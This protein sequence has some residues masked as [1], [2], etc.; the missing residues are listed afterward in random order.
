VLHKL[1]SLVERQPCLACNIAAKLMLLMHTLYLDVVQFGIQLEQSP[2]RYENLRLMAGY[3][4][5]H[6]VAMTSLIDM[7]EERQL[8]M[9]EQTL[10]REM[11]R[12]L[13]TLI[14]GTMLSTGEDVGSDLSPR[15]QDHHEDWAASGKKIEDL[16]DPASIQVAIA[17]I[18]YEIQ[19]DMGG[20]SRRTINK[21]L[22]KPVRQKG[23]KDMASHLLIRL[24]TWCSEDL[25]YRIL[26]QFS[27][28]EVFHFQTVRTC[29]L[30]EL[31]F[32]TNLGKYLIDI[33]PK[34]LHLAG[35]QLAFY[36][37]VY[38]LNA[39]T[40][41]VSVMLLCGTASKL[42]LLLPP[43][44]G[45]PLGKDHNEKH[46]HRC[47][48][49]LET[50]PNQIRSIYRG[51]GKQLLGFQ[52]CNGSST[53]LA[54]LRRNARDSIAHFLHRASGDQPELRANMFTDP[55]TQA[56]V[57]EVVTGTVLAAS[58]TTNPVASLIEGRTVETVFGLEGIPRLCVLTSTE[59]YEFS[60][61]FVAWTAADTAAPYFD[62]SE[63]ARRSVQGGQ[64]GDGSPSKQSATSLSKADA[65]DKPKSG[66]RPRFACTLPGFYSGKNASAQ[67]GTEAPLTLLKSCPLPPQKVEF[68][69]GLHPD[70][71]IQ[72]SQSIEIRFCTDGAREEWR[73]VLADICSGW[74]RN[75]ED[76]K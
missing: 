30:M 24:L 61:D 44:T 60:L 74:Q 58:V 73:R 75:G 12:C 46:F 22:A 62:E 64:L 59:V 63:G 54:F 47:S 8:A 38:C 2:P 45:G 11:C 14:L 18:L 33:G 4:S 57:E 66:S 29:Y 15:G 17:F 27:Q 49:E 52:W 25:R 68:D 1:I 36:E 26:E 28:A 5:Q 51:Y 43:S 72:G 31:L 67:E 39:A 6:A 76:A 70:L 42:W 34:T 20:G 10:G 3:I 13:S 55:S 41:T 7:T 48:I 32:N 23:L 37:P 69:V 35:S 71:S 53:L 19:M 40:S 9:E 50:H 56:A 65:K 16:V 21:E